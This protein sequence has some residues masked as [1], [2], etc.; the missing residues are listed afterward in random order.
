MKITVSCV[1]CQK[2]VAHLDTTKSDLN[3][4][5]EGHLAELLVMSQHAAPPH[6]APHALVITMDGKVIK[7][8]SERVKY[9]VEC[10]VC[11]KKSSFPNLPS[12]CVGAVT[13]CFHSVHEGHPMRMVVND[14]QVYP[15]A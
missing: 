3:F 13:I 11:H 1:E 2:E 8:P 9:E 15:P 12:Y 10:L 4:I 7:Q 6:Q 14:V 5:E